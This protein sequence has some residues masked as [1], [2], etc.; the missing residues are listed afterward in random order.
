MD[1]AFS[2]Q[3]LQAA[4]CRAETQMVSFDVFDT[5]I[6]RPFW[7]PA[8]LFLLMD[9]EATR[10]LQAPMTVDFSSYRRE[11]EAAA[12]REAAGEGREDVSLSE[13]YDHLLKTGFFPETAVRALME[14]EQEMEMK[15]CRP[16]ESA[17]EL[18]KLALREGKRVI[19]VSDMY[20]P[21]SVIEGILVR[22]G[23]PVPERIFVSGQIGLTK[24]S[25]HLYG[26]VIR[27]TGVPGS[28]IVHIGDNRRSDVKK[29]REHGIRAFLYN[30]PAELMKGRGCPRSGFYLRRAYEGISSPL[31][32]NRAMENLGVRCMLAVAANRLFDDPFRGLSSE[33][34]RGITA[35]D[36]TVA[37]GMY[38]MAHA[39]WIDEVAREEKAERVLFFSRDEYLIRH[40]YEL[41]QDHREKGR[42]SAYFRIS[43]KARLALLL[44]GRDLMYSVG[45]FLYPQGQSPASLTRLFSSVLDEEKVEKLRRESGEGWTR[46]FSGRTE[47]VLFLE[48]FRDSCVRAEK[49][50]AYRDGFLKYAAP[51]MASS[52][53]T[54]DVGFSLGTEAILRHF[55]PGTRMTSCMTHILQGN[56][57]LLRGEA[58]G[59]GIRTLYPVV[60]FVS[61]A[62]R[63]IFQSEDGPTCEGYGGDGR[64]LLEDGHRPQE[65]IRA[66]HEGA[67]AFMEDFT[68]LFG[69][70][71]QGLPMDHLA[72]C[73]PFEAFLHSPDRSEKRMFRTLRFDDPFGGNT[74]GRLFRRNWQSGRLNYWSARHHL[75]KIPR[76]GVQFFVCLFT[77]PGKLKR[78]WS[79]CREALRRRMGWI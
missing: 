76:Y 14:T 40:G 32:G 58:G 78:G 25:G 44:T 67:L 23:I 28:R 29:A 26:Y 34:G 47:M 11:A 1:L 30:R 56:L 60:P 15:Y 18:L 8:D 5:L 9:R 10:L 68:A 61:F 16:R 71:V 17:K 27:E 65:V 33:K 6:V 52:V 59:I 37:L 49:L 4:I 73:L 51:L 74:R 79:R 46:E 72:A 53:V 66:M 69:E 19:A 39:L 62:A 24:H 70:D 20:L 41:L 38:C 64:A 22:N 54:C 63:E 21:A 35:W 75:R 50:Q 3:T 31:S 36:G 7:E 77:D 13:I 48:K 45:T 57:P 2:A 42:A 12:R 43:R 55:F